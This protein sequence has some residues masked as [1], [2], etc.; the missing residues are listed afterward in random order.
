VR[1]SEA[2]DQS[3]VDSGAFV[4]RR[5][6]SPVA[7]TVSYDAATHSVRIRPAAPL[8]H[9]TAYTVEVNGVRDAAGNA[10]ASRAAWSFATAQA[11][12]GGTPPTDPPQPNPTP[13]QAVRVNAGG[14]AI[15]IAGTAWSGCR[16]TP[17]CSGWVER[18]FARA[19]RGSRRIANA[20]ASSPASLYRT[21]WTGS[22][23]RRGTP[24]FTFELPVRDGDYRVRLH[25]AEVERM[26]QG[27]RMFDVEVEEGW[28]ALDDLDVVAESGGR[29]RALVRELPV[30][31]ED[32]SASIAFVREKGRPMVS[33]IEVIPAP[34]AQRP[35]A[36]R[37]TLGARGARKVT[38]VGAL[39]AAGRSLGSRVVVLEARAR[40]ARRFAPLGTARTRAD[41]TFRFKAGV[42]RRGTT[43]R[44]RFAGD[45]AGRAVRRSLSVGR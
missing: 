39:S 44:V 2:L 24:A 20:T 29:N 3:T 36:S 38:L 17:F 4:L 19:V 23:G 32:G 13:Q 40:K 9:A 12:G 34:S 35:A 31:V 22:A 21:Y 27:G 18:G 10:L 26:R 11:P 25:F 5:G 14:P 42:L 43:V 33:A 7:R 15:T 37:L 28:A 16:S 30:R 8:A 41:G 6:S 45:A 1:F